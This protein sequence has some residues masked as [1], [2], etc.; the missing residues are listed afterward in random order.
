MRFFNKELDF[1]QLFTFAQVAVASFRTR[2]RYL[3]VSGKFLALT[4]LISST[5]ISASYYDKYQS[6]ERLKPSASVDFEAYGRD[7][8]LGE[9]S[10][11]GNFSIV[12]WLH[13]ECLVRSLDGRFGD[14]LSSPPPDDFM[15]ELQFLPVRAN[16]VFYLDQSQ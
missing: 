15:S 10:L 2:V 12:C 4:L 1:N 16:F 8:E 3:S 11:V 14:F 9:Q 5:G 7:L 6:L 13:G